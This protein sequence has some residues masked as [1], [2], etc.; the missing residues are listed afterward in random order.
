MIRLKN[1]I[2]EAPVS[3]HQ[4]IGDFSK[5]HSFHKKVDRALV[6]NPVSVKKVKDFFKNT[7][8]DFDFYFVNTTEARKFME[9]GKVKK[10]FI[11]DEMGIKPEQLKDGI[12]N[13]NS[14]TVFFTN[15]RGDERA[16]LTPWIIAHR[17][18][19]VFRR[20]Y[21]WEHYLQT[22]VT[23]EIQGIMECYGISPKKFTGW[24]LGDNYASVKRYEIALRYLCEAIGTFKSARDKNLRS[25]SEFQYELFA[26]YLKDGEIKLNP[27]PDILPTGQHAY[28]NLRFKSP[29]DK[30]YAEGHIRELTR[31][32][33][34]YAESVLNDC[35]GN[36]FV[37]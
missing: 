17:L 31:D 14:I 10:D 33:R 16:P 36:I 8:A 5:G 20:E 24:G 18:G 4:T 22:W 15:N 37:M 12:I 19:H 28:R 35:I 29:E 26:Q 3:T 23:G 30:E 21:A 2:T 27:C 6:T 11:F 7:S 32:Y 25:E 34:H 1:I 9:L 13:P